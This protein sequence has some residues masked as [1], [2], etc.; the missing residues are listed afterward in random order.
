MYERGRKRQIGYYDIEKAH[1]ELKP[2]KIFKPDKEFRPKF[3]KNAALKITL[4]SAFNPTSSSTITIMTG[5]PK[6]SPF[7]SLSGTPT[8]IPSP[9]KVDLSKIDPK[10]QD[11]FVEFTPPPPLA[12]KTP[13]LLSEFEAVK[14]EIPDEVASFITTK[15][16]KQPQTT[17][18]VIYKFYENLE[19]VP[20]TKAKY[21]PSELASATL[22]LK[23]AVQPVLHYYQEQLLNNLFPK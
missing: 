20:K 8:P 23:Y 16:P 2:N 10:Y 15:G 22:H 18:P 9:I 5:L 1:A 4:H 19:W 17:I 11:L 12:I 21:E 13:E 3:K 7:G 14:K 6:P